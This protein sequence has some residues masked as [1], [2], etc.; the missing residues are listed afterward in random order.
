MFMEKI[1]KLF[2]IK[3]TLVLYDAILYFATFFLMFVLNKSIRDMAVRDILINVCVGFLII[4]LCR[5]IGRIYNQI[6]RYGGIQCY[7]RLLCTD[8]LGMILYTGF[9]YG[10]CNLLNFERFTISKIIAMLSFNT[11]LALGMRMSYRYCFKYSNELSA[12]GKVM[13]ALLRIFA[14]GLDVKK[15]DNSHKIYV[16]IVGA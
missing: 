6:W 16:A 1:K 11:L 3:W 13:R 9:E 8:V 15:D 2:N 5:F 10:F 4:F 14:F 7:I 12:K